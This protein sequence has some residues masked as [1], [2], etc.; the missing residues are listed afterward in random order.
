MQMRAHHVVDI[1][2]RKTGRRERA[3][4][5]VVGLH[6]PFRTRRPRLQLRTAGMTE[7]ARMSIAARPSF[8][9]PYWAAAVIMTRS[10]SGTIKMRCPPQPK[11][12]T[13]FTSLAP[14]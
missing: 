3:Q 1:G 7:L 2:H 4:I 14:E 10:R 9:L 11:A 8:G 5:G 13:H 6:V 12:A